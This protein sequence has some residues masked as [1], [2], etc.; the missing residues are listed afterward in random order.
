MSF[1]VR[2]LS[3]D[4]KKRRPLPWKK[5]GTLLLKCSGPVLAI[6]EFVVARAEKLSEEKAKK[7]ERLNVLKRVLVILITILCAA[8]LFA[9]TVKALMHLKV[10]NVKSL[11]SVA[12]TDLP[13]DGFGHTNVLLLGKGDANHDGIDLTDTI[14]IASIDPGNTKSVALLSLPRDLYF[15]QTEKIGKGR[16]NTLYRDYKSLLIREGMEKEAAETEALTEVAAEVGRTVGIEIHEA[17]MVDFQGF[18]EAVDAIGG[19]DIEVPEDL[20]D[21]EYPDPLNESAFITFEVKAGPQHLDG[22]TALKYA[23]SRHSTSDFDR[24]R[25]QQQILQAIGD[26]VKSGGVLSKPNR[27]LDLVNILK[28]HVE[29]TLTVREMLGLA[30]LGGEIDK[31]NL[32]TMQLNDQN[33]L[34]GSVVRP[35]GLLYTPPRAQFGGASVLL[36]VSI[37]PEP[38]T[39]KQI[40]MLTSLLSEHR[41]MF[42]DRTPIDV[43]NAGAK[44]G[45]GRKQSDELEKFGFVIGRV[46]NSDNAEKLDTTV[47]RASEENRVKATF[48]ADLLKLKL[49]IIPPETAAGMD[50]SAI[51]ILLGKDYIYAPLQSTFQP[52]P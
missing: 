52:R 35:G 47:I 45:S 38:I 28:E 23:R 48:V 11:V 32:L 26:T 15:L 37:P 20:L 22:E 30:K 1:T 49:E 21:T 46:A 6:G 4:K 18:V 36:P 27:I 24:S 33:G 12:A 40:N 3:D 7:K 16:I 39:W 13:M 50:T 17:L 41:A 19:V 8:L 9:S 25:R 31:A 34:Y 14:M 51:V 44:P 42:V 2:R 10:L 29:T 43:L 5:W